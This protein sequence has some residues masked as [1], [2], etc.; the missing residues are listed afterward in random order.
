M[1]KVPLFTRDELAAAFRLIISAPEAERYA[2]MWF[3]LRG[4]CDAE[5]RVMLDVSVHADPETLRAL[6]EGRARRGEEPDTRGTGGFELL[7]GLSDEEK[8]EFLMG[9]SDFT[10]DLV[11]LSSPS[12]AERIRLALGDTPKQ[13]ERRLAQM[14]RIVAVIRE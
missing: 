14:R 7:R 13:A 6:E 4:D 3:E 11:S 5:G 12:A 10:L 1:Q 9:Y 8:G 2:T